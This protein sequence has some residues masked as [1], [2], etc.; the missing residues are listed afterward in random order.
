MIG[1]PIEFFHQPEPSNKRPFSRGVRAGG[2]VYISGHSAPCNPAN[3]I[4]RGET[5]AEEVKNALQYMTTLLQ[6]AGS[7][8]DL[9]VQITMLIN[10]KADYAALNEEYVQHF[11]NGL[12]ARHTALFGVPTE[13]RVAFACVALAE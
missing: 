9:V 7:R 10:H 12:P 4:S 6:D 8:L 3:G 11:P 5:P 1:E 2:M 13:A